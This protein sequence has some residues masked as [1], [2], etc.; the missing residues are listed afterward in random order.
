MC[1]VQRIQLRVLQRQ[2]TGNGV[3]VRV[4]LLLG[5]PNGGRRLTV[6]PIRIGRVQLHIVHPNL[7]RV[8]RQ[9]RGRR[10]AKQKYKANGYR[11]AR[12]LKLF[13]STAPPLFIRRTECNHPYWFACASQPPSPRLPRTAA[14]S[15]PTAAR[16]CAVAGLRSRHA[17]PDI[18]KGRRRQRV[19]GRISLCFQ[20]SRQ[21]RNTTAVNRCRLQ[22]P[23]QIYSYRGR[24]FSGGSASSAQHIGEPSPIKVKHPP[25]IDPPCQS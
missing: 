25:V 13:H 24:V 16:P 23:K 10:Q 1:W 17:N 7:R 15:P 22:F 19:R 8:C 18:V 21:R 9:C 11:R 14:Q 5:Q 4:P 3:E 20:A 6:L 2:R 12:F